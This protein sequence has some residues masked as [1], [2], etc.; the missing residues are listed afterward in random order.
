MSPS[1]DR[2]DTFSDNYSIIERDV[3]FDNVQGREHTNHPLSAPLPFVGQTSTIHCTSLGYRFLSKHHSLS[4][5]IPAGALSKPTDIEIGVLLSGPLQFPDSVVPVSAVLWLSTKNSK[6]LKFSKLVQISMSHCIDFSKPE[7]AKN[8]V[9][10][11]AN[12]HDSIIEKPFEFTDISEPAK[13]LNRRGNFS[14]KQTSLFCIVH[15]VP[16]MVVEKANFCLISTCTM[17]KSVMDSNRYEMNFC[18]SYG[19]KTCIKVCMEGGE[20][21]YCTNYYFWDS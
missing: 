4:I 2:S 20:G 8:V 9:V 21:I 14:T 12:I 11:K 1:F 5:T 6:P 18:V 15:R 19:I 17:P 13:F 7:E 10:M 16:S 3:V